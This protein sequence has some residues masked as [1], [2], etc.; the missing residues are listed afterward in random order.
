MRR[1]NGGRNNKRYG[2]ARS[3]W[4]GT[5]QITSAHESHG[6]GVNPAIPPTVWTE[7]RSPQLR[8][9]NGRA[10]INDA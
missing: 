8:Q 1:K 6:N 9:V 2:H 5:T 4:G 7:K 10:T 3:M